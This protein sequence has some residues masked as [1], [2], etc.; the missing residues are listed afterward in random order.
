MKSLLFSFIASTVLLGACGPTQEDYRDA[1]GTSGT[2]EYR[3]ERMSGDDAAITSEVEANLLALPELESDVASGRIEV[4]TAGGVVTL[5]GKIA[6]EAE[7][8]NAVSMAWSVAGVTE[9]RDRLGMDAL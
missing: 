1:T 5:D 4:D 3:A 2:A 8:E 6:S 9:V 7:R